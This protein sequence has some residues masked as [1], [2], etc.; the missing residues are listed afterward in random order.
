M[1]CAP[2]SESSGARDDKTT[3]PGLLQIGSAPRITTPQGAFGDNNMQEIAQETETNNL[4]RD[5]V[6]IMC[7]R[8]ERTWIDVALITY[9]NCNYTSG[10]LRA[11][12]VE[13]MSSDPAAPWDPL[14]INVDVAPWS[15]PPGAYSAWAPG[16]PDVTVTI[17]TLEIERICR[18]LS[19]ISYG[20]VM[21]WEAES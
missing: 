6:R 9:V 8:G 11:R 4:R 18:Q 7:S 12:I 1:N 14:E 21:E 19:V 5:Q 13:L 10:Q 15:K 17:E 20:G 3:A 2:S 16:N